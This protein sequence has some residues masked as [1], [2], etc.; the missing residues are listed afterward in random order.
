M[1]YEL[2]REIKRSVRAKMLPS[3]EWN[4]WNEL[5]EC[6]KGCVLY[7]NGVCCWNKNATAEGAPCVPCITQVFAKLDRLMGK[8]ERNG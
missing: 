1:R 3:P 5:P 8:R 2:K 7:V 6:R 4:P